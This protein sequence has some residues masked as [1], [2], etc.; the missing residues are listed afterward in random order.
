MEAREVLDELEKGEV[1]SLLTYNT[2]IV[3]MCERGE[4]CEAA[5]LWDEMVE[6]GRA[7]NAFTY[8]VLIKGF[9][10]VGDVKEGIRVLEEMVE[11]GCLPNKSTY[12]ILVDGISVSGGKKEEIE[13]VVLLAMT[14]G[15]DGGLWGIF[16]K[17][18][19]NLDGN[20]AMLDRILTENV[21]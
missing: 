16:L 8:N 13:K 12:S 20:A 1:A 14:T 3:G 17:L 2:L 9:C 21:V 15:V 7:P 11:N 19:G 18:V 4:L 5:R 10:K 6:K